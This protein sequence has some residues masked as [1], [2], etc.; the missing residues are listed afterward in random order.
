MSSESS[1]ETKETIK[2][3]ESESPFSITPLVNQPK[4]SLKW[5][6]DRVLQL[7]LENLCLAIEKNEWPSFRGI[8]SICMPHSTTPSIAT[9]DSSP[10]PSTPCSLSSASQEHTPHPTP[11]HTPRRESQSPFTG[12]Y[13]YANNSAASINSN[14]LNSYENDTTRRRRRRRRRFE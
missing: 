11:D 6:R 5:P 12:D 2:P 7:R 13:F 14:L 10:R 9:A 1:N 8:N 4:P 3:T